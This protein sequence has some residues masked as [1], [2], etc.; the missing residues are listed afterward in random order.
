M[1]CFCFCICF[2]FSLSYFDLGVADTFEEF[3]EEGVYVGLVGARFEKTDQ[4]E[5]TQMVISQR[6]TEE[7]GYGKS[8]Y[9]F[10]LI[11]Y[12]FFFIL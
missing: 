6:T 10:F 3:E 11:F 8:L 9:F 2:L 5:S 1:F 4:M 7:A 12:L